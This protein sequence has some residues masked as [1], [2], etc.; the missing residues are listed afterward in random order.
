MG[1]QQSQPTANSSHEASENRLPFVINLKT[2]T[3]RPKICPRPILGP[4]EVQL[5]VTD[6]S[7]MR[8]LYALL[9]DDIDNNPRRNPR[10]L[11]QPK[12]QDAIVD[13]RTPSGLTIPT[14]PPETCLLVVPEYE[15][16]I[17]QCLNDL[18]FGRLIPHL[19][20]V[21]VVETVLEALN[22]REPRMIHY[23][24]FESTRR[25]YKDLREKFSVRSVKACF[26][27]YKWKLFW[28]T[29]DGSQVIFSQHCSEVMVSVV[30]VGS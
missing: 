13:V 23:R 20:E 24:P 14:V 28:Q 22:V 8:R 18:D 5:P 10:N 6:W 16:M 29:Q 12:Y 7:N 25:D 15:H 30:I 19:E 9:Y 26:A 2:T 17:L 27:E 21:I 3:C 11:K 1:G 4:G